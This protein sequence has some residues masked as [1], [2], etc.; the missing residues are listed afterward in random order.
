[1]G[2]KNFITYPNELDKVHWAAGKTMVYIADKIYRKM[3]YLSAN[4]VIAINVRI[5]IG[6]LKLL[7]EQWGMDCSDVFIELLKEDWKEELING[8]L[9]MRY[10]KYI[11]RINKKSCDKNS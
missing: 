9:Y 8:A 5:A 1:M 6:A 7:K 2:T 10:K 4:M 11:E 3:S